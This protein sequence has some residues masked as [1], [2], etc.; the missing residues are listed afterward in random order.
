MKYHLN[1]YLLIIITLCSNISH[2]QKRR[3]AIRDN[4]IVPD[5]TYIQDEGLFNVYNKNDKWYLE[6][7][8]SL[9][10]R[11]LMAV[12]RYSSLISGAPFFAGELSNEMMI[13]FDKQDT[14]RMLLRAYGNV[15]ITDMATPISVAVKKSSLSPIIKS[16][17]ILG[18][19]T[20]S[21]YIIDV[22][23]F[24]LSDANF[25]M[26]PDLKTVFGIS[27]VDNSRSFVRSIKS[28]P[29]NTEFKVLKTFNALN[30]SR[31]KAAKEIGALSIEFNTSII[32]LPKRPMSKRVYDPR[33][34][35]FWNTYDS[36][37][38]TSVKA[39]KIKTIVRWRLEPK[40]KADEIKQ[41]NGELIEPA[42]QIVFY[43]DPATPD[44][45]K[46]YLKQGVDDWNVAFEHA[47]W[48]NA[49]RGE[50]WPTDD[51][52][53]SLEDARYSVIRYLASP[54]ENAYGPNVNDPRSGEIIESHVCWYH[55]LMKLLH[56]WYFIQTA[57]A[58][59]SARG[60]VYED[61]V[62]GK[63]IRF[64]S[65]HEIGHALG[66]MHN[67]MSS[68][69]TPV[70]KLRD[71][72][73]LDIYGHTSSIMDYARFNYVA[74]PQDGVTDFSPRINDYDKWAIK[75]GYSYL[76]KDKSQEQEN[77]IL[78]EWVKEAYENKRLHY[79]FEGI[80]TDPRSQM[81]DLGDDAIIA[82]EYG[83]QN[84]KIIVDSLIYW[85]TTPGRDYSDL[86]TMYQAVEKQFNRY[87]GHVITYIGGVYV[88]PLTSEM[89]GDV[90]K[91]VEYEKQVKALD[92][93]SQNLFE[94]P[95]WL[96]VDG[97]LNKIGQERK[98][99]YLKRW[100]TKAIAMLLD[101]KRLQRLAASGEKEF[102]M[103]DL[104]EG[105]SSKIFSDNWISDDI[106]QFERNLQWIYINSLLELY[107]VEKR[108]LSL[109]RMNM[110]GY[111][112]D[113][114]DS[115]MKPAIR[116]ALLDILEK[117]DKKR[118]RKLSVTNSAHFDEIKKVIKQNIGA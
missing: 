3:D 57:A 72:E 68:Y 83:I 84:L 9:I 103:F 50:Y 11:D 53:M 28:Y 65:S 105:I 20:D 90:F 24:L 14:S 5:S 32:L 54:Y 110:G 77:M 34:G 44:K 94:A 86:K 118:L 60:M 26:K 59:P 46:P 108:K 117:S 7:H 102:N 39:E 62:M 67:M 96:L 45:W 31:I 93:I 100:Q 101:G 85:T 25:F 15:V 10:G 112:N 12:T 71:K 2:A 113:M 74:Q 17:D 64:V 114:L 40:S 87:V 78:N 38:E 91:V 8:D 23:D 70:E 16:F 1:I 18:G 33:I 106:G 81:E 89:E 115:D 43:I 13:H 49:I 61:T 41:M 19:T 95:R 29:I 88:N 104:F 69:A 21:H 6:I 56:E 109:E 66:L 76:G 80:T 35:Y 58:N 52:T 36:F 47:G 116:S 51:T 82:S 79:T 97:I 111:G 55:N 42:K 98:A 92:F 27:N 22:S 30:N 75:W 4:I 107:S 63:L 48:K 99:D 73:W 37:S